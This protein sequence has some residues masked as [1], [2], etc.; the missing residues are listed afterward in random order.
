MTRMALPASTSTRSLVVRLGLTRQLTF[1]QKFRSCGWHP[2]VC[3]TEDQPRGE[4]QQ[5]SKVEQGAV[6]HVGTKQMCGHKAAVSG[7]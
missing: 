3:A 6:G 2:A 7:T 5:V 4:L 1:V